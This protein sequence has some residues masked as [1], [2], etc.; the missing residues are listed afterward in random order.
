MDQQFLNILNKLDNIGKFKQAD[1]LENYIKV[2]QFRGNTQT[3]GNVQNPL[4]SFFDPMAFV[5]GQESFLPEIVSGVGRK[6][7]LNNVTLRQLSPRE[8]ELYKYNP[9]FRMQFEQAAMDTA[10][11][12]SQGKSVNDLKTFISRID[13][14]LTLLSYNMKPSEIATQYEQR[15]DNPL[16]NQIKNVLMTE[17][18]MNTVYN[19]FMSTV[20]STKY[21][22]YL[23]SFTN[24]QS[25]TF[26]KALNET[27]QTLIMPESRKDINLIQ[28]YNALLN[29]PRF[30]KYIDTTLF[31]PI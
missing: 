24:P 14:A 4:P 16:Q 29:D 28:K 17:R 15:F 31:K 10:L 2:S 26:S 5:K 3:K 6:L 19:V 20:N 1:I 7:D 18:N 23:D 21:L 13:D 22:K 30:R 12:F 27:L 11:S 8:L 9:Q 25:G